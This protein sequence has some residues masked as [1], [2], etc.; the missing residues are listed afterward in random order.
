VSG[1]QRSPAAQPESFARHWRNAPHDSPAGQ[2]PSFLHVVRLSALQGA[3]SA[4]STRGTHWPP[5]QMVP[6][7]EHGEAVLQASPQNEVPSGADRQR[8][9]GPQSP[10]C[11]HASQKARRSRQVRDAVSHQRPSPQSAS[12]EQPGGSLTQ[13]PVYGSHCSRAGQL[14]SPSHTQMRRSGWQR[15]AMHSASSE[16]AAPNASFAVR[17]PPGA[18]SARSPLEQARK[19]QITSKAAERIASHAGSCPSNAHPGLR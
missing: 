18:G 8:F 14:S 13:R 3:T 11:S 16:H 2:S 19:R 17:A 9:P 5:S 15:P 1:S 12:R 10:S 6:G 7:R 4:Q